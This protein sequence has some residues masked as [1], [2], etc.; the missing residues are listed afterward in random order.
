M[1]L[2]LM[3]L[4]LDP[5]APAAHAG[6][7]PGV[8]HDRESWL[9][10]IFSK[11]IVFLHRGADFH[12][13]PLPEVGTP[14][15]MVGR[16]GRRVVAVENQ[17]PQNFFSETEHESWRAALVLIDPRAHE[18]G[19][20][21]AAEMVPEVG[22]PLPIMDSLAQSIN[23]GTPPEPYFVEVNAITDT[24][25]FW[26]FEKENRGHIVDITFELHVPNMFGIRDDL[27]KELK[28]L[29]DHERARRAKF[30]IQNEDGLNLQTD[31]VANTVQ[32]TLDG[33]GAVKARTDDGKRFNSRRRV[34]RETVD[35]ELPSDEAPPTLAERVLRAISAVFGL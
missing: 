26:D 6:V 31:R 17:P 15:I 23:T 21:I 12:F 20:L 30:E 19:Q 35:V 24:K 29:R 32:H 1:Q 34:R 8:P 14:E 9:R 10:A 5:R 33:G 2:F 27:D 3:R 22:R 11:E 16:V 13:V 4:M 7:R 18:N 28:E 25:T